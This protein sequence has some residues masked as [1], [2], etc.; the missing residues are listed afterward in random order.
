MRRLKWKW[1]SGNVESDENDLFI[2][3]SDKKNINICMQT[4]LIAYQ[5]HTHSPVI[6]IIIIILPC[7]DMV[8][9]AKKKKK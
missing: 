9:L 3:Q 7:D 4:I 8:M 2:L 1:K 6:I 5:I